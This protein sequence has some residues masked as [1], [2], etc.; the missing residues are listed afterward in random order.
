MAWSAESLTIVIWNTGK[1]LF[2]I[3]L[4]WISPLRKPLLIDTVPLVFLIFFFKLLSTVQNFKE[5]VEADNFGTHSMW[6]DSIPITL[7]YLFVRLFLYTKYF[8]W[9]FDWIF[10]CYIQYNFEYLYVQSSSY[11][12]YLCWSYLLVTYTV[13]IWYVSKDFIITVRSVNC[14]FLRAQSTWRIE[15]KNGKQWSCLPLSVPFCNIQCSR[16]WASGSWVHPL[17]VGLAG[18]KLCT[19]KMQSQS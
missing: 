17:G 5:T 7:G 2:S 12:Q 8:Y 18:G 10:L 4:Y 16:Q 11:T 13:T 15:H 9:L 1:K 6:I 3:W 14:R 19:G